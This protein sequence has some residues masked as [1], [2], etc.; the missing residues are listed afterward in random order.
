MTKLAR[1]LA[2]TALATGAFVAS[3]DAGAVTITVSGSVGGAPVGATNYVTF[4]S[5]ALG[6]AGGTDGGITVSFTG[7]AQ[8]VINSLSGKYAAPFLSGGNGALFGNANG[9]DTTRYLSTGTGTVTLQLPGLMQYLGLLWG[10]VDSY[11]ALDFYAGATLLDTITG[12]EVTASPNGNQGV[13]GTLYVNFSSDTPFDRVVARSSSYA[14]EFDNVAYFSGPTP[15]GDPVSA[16]ATL[17]LFGA[18]LAGLG[19]ARRRAA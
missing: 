11:N 13:N 19:I 9:V 17:A 3:P 5:L 16:P 10:S 6:N 4:N 15:A 8:T 1:L 12:S 2:V 14:F 7:T 18:A